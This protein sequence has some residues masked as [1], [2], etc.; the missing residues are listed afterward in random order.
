MSKTECNFNASNLTISTCTVLCNLGNKINLEYMTRF[1]PIYNITAPELEDKLGGIYNMEFY[2][3]CARGETLSDRIKDEFNNQTTIKIKYWGFRMVNVKVFRNGK[4]QITGLKSQEEAFTIGNILINIL[5]N[6]K[7]PIN[8][9]LDTIINARP[10]YDLQLI[11]DG[12]RITYFRRYFHRFL[13][14]FNF[15][16]EE[17]YYKATTNTSNS[18]T[19]PDIHNNVYKRIKVDIKRKNFINGLHDTYVDSNVFTNDHK[20]ME[21]NEWFSDSRILEI[22]DII[23]FAKGLFQTDISNCLIQ[24]ITFKTLRW[25]LIKLK[26]KYKD[27][28]N[29]QLNHI[30]ENI[31]KEYYTFD[32]ATLID[33]KN[34]LN[35][36]FKEYINQL[37]K[38]INRLLYIR[39]CDISVC[40]D[41][42]TYLKT[43]LTTIIKPIKKKN[44]LETI[45]LLDIMGKPIYNV[46]NIETVMINSDL[47]VPYNINLKKMTVALKNMGIFNSY[48]P[49]EHSAVKL[50]YY[51][52]KYSIQSTNTTASNEEKDKIP[53]FC[54]CTPHCSTKEK[55]SPCSKITILI[56]R[57]GSIIITGSRTLEQLKT[58]HAFTLT[59]LKETRENVMIDDKDDDTKKQA[60][61]NNENR[62][63]LKKHRLFF[64]KISDIINLPTST[65]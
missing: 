38:K 60:I 19:T 28:R 7:V 3:N 57:P 45:S 41:A 58:A 8:T 37:E 46:S 56:F 18:N 36:I 10:T 4:L 27:F 29:S 43:V 49:D 54:Y 59:I 50:K 32:E 52:N 12:T 63:M 14:N 26:G 55:K 33:V 42:D 23:H 47:T 9:S 39:N 11:W 20:K 61:L 24:S 6:V 35:G 16:L 22:I 13:H 51:W 64:V 65:K 17:Q 53:G 30:I 34:Q 44:K 62:K 31:F 5:N 15:N 1:V 2:G 48:D 40:N 21:A 25:N